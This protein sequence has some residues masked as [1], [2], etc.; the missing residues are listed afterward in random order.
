MILPRHGLRRQRSNGNWP[1]SWGVAPGWYKSAPLALNRYLHPGAGAVP[2][3]R[4][5][6]R[7]DVRMERSPRTIPRASCSPR[8]CG[9]QAARRGAHAAGVRFS[10]ARR[11]LVPPPFSGGGEGRAR[12]DGLGGPPKPARGPRAL[13]RF[14]ARARKTAPEGGCAPRRGG[15]DTAQRAK[16][17]S[18]ALECWVRVGS[19]P[20][21][22]RDERNRVTSRLCRPCRDF[23]GHRPPTQHS[24]AG[25]FSVVPA[26]LSQCAPII[27][28][29]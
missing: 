29:S 1:A 8:F 25:L 2:G 28:K 5:L 23:P 27:A 26:G 9:L 16:D 3:A 14:S 7:R 18:P 17:N 22:G 4:R 24:S 15:P 13:P 10:A 6:R 19:E 21:P 12:N 11:K 20:S